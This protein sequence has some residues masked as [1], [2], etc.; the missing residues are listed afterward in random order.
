MGKRIT[1]KRKYKKTQTRHLIKSKRQTNR[2]V[3][4]ENVVKECL[5]NEAT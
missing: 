3:G 1:I 4:K 5:E 2:N